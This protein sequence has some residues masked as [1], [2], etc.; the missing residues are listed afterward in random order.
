MV[1]TC[2][3]C[4]ANLSPSSTSC[5]SCG[6]PRRS[7]STGGS[8]GGG[9]FCGSCGTALASKFAP[10][11]KCG[12]VKTTFAPPPQSGGF[13]G[14]CGGPLASKFAPCPKCGHVKTTFNPSVPAQGF[15]YKSSGTTNLLSILCS[16]LLGTNG[17]GHLYLGQIGKGIAL[18]IG[19]WLLVAGIV[20]GIMLFV[21]PGIICGIAALILW[22]WSMIDANKQCKIYNDFVAQNGRAPW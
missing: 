20:V 1:D 5:P 9:G 2:V 7:P 19:G 22:I 12:H 8:S 18:M 4:G 10:C 6:S 17:V 13:C 15:L 16:L 21:V 14:G 11:P 3:N